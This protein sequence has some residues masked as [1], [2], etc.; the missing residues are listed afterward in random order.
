MNQKITKMVIISY[1]NGKIQ[2]QDVSEQLQE[3]PLNLIKKHQAQ[4]PTDLQV[5]LAMWI[6]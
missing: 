4:V 1:R 6:S 2:V 5:T 3:W